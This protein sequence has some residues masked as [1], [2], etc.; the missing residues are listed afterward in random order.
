[1]NDNTKPTIIIYDAISDTAITR[2]MTEDE[3]A[4][5][6]NPLPD[7]LPKEITE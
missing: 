2:E 1:M 5:I 6:L 7:Y 4:A 3:I